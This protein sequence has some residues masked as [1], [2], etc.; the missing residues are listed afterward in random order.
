MRVGNITKYL[1]KGLSAKGI[2]VALLLFI[3]ATSVLAGNNLLVGKLL[4][5]GT[6][7]RPVTYKMWV[8]TRSGDSASGSAIYQNSYTAYYA[9]VLN[10][11]PNWSNNEVV[12]AITEKDDGRYSVTDLTL[13]GSASTQNFPDATFQPI[14][15]PTANPGSGAITVSWPAAVDSGTGNI[16]GYNVYRSADGTNFSQINGSIVAASP[17]PSYSDASGT[18]GITYYYKIKIVFRGEPNKVVSTNFSAASSGVQFPNAPVSVT[19]SSL[20]HGTVGVAYNRTLEAT[21]GNGTYAW[22]ISS[23]SLPTGLGLNASTGVISGT[24][25]AAGTSNFTV[26]VTSNG[27]A[28]KSLLIVVDPA[29]VTLVS[30]A[31]TPA[32]PNVMVDQTKQFTATG[33]YSDLST[34]NITG[35]V[36]WQSLNIGVATM[37]GNTA[38]GVAPGTATIKA[39]S[40]AISG[41]TTLTV[42]P[43][44]PHP[45]ITRSPI[46]FNLSVTQG[47][48]VASQ[49]FTVGNSGDATLNYTITD[50]QNWLSET[51]DSGII[52][53]GGAS[54]TITINFDTTSLAQGPH[55]ATITVSDPGASNDPQ[56]I[57]VAL[58]VNPAPQ[59]VLSVD[60]AS[61]A[62]S[63]TQGQ[64]AA[65][66]N[67]TISN[68][69]NAGLNY[70]ITKDQS[71]LDVNKT[72]RTVAPSGS[73]SVNIVFNTTALSVGL[74]I[75]HITITDPSANGS[76]KTVT[77]NLN[78]TSAPLPVAEVIPSKLTVSAG[79]TI[80]ITLK[81]SESNQ[82]TTS[83]TA[84]NRAGLCDLTPYFSGIQIHGTTSINVVP[85]DLDHIV[86]LPH[87]V[88]LEQGRSATFTA[89]GYDVYGNERT[90]DIFNYAS[91]LGDNSTVTANVA[92]GDYVISAYKDG[93]SD[94][95]DIKVTSKYNSLIVKVENGKVK[96]SA[97]DALGSEVALPANASVAYDITGK[98]DGNAVAADGTIVEGS[99]EGDF[100]VTAT[101]TIGSQTLT[102]NC[103]V[104]INKN[105]PTIQAK[106]DN[107]DLANNIA[108]SSKP[109]IEINLT[110]GNGV[111]AVRIFI[112]GSEMTGFSL[113]A[114]N[115][116]SSSVSFTPDT[117][118]GSGSHALLIEAE[119]NLG[120]KSSVSAQGLKVYADLQVQG[121]PMN[122][123]NP[124]KPSVGNTTIN[125]RLTKDAE[126]KLMIY[127]FTGRLVYTQVFAAGSNGGRVGENDPTWNGK[128]FT[129]ASAGNGVCVYFITAGGKSIG[130]GEISIYE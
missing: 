56:T 127:D 96:L 45:I 33:T 2:L 4:P 101:V 10:F 128:S 103:I 24:P 53:Q 69:G 95:A 74:K 46:S 61:F 7:Y 25:T 119:D 100:T 28:T 57:S 83:W 48:N 26:E 102:G 27:T 116:A 11:S 88:T 72:S 125:Y 43:P 113:R 81:Y 126:V 68:T 30:I 15:N 31:V 108:I 104:N 39:T 90:G 41:Q 37:S 121:K 115:T 77:V 92:A 97:K 78:V 70:T 64:N 38:T 42:I 105:G 36:I 20:P 55:N 85:A 66:Q 79:E 82:V 123:P 17:S 14:P 106:I 130:S 110:D 93:K 54:Q 118:L 71:W 124:F 109:N 13:N 40:G 98:A 19:T 58:T 35:S 75:A 1:N 117:S 9:N 120:T 94:V 8:A 80:N 44:A 6:D 107:Q 65:N 89:K 129:G 3:T 16:A 73:D 87:S 50:N 76:P 5:A 52:A 18:S 23:G 99:Q 91:D 47:Q 86:I 84:P 32:N 63:V 122:Y 21:G 22:A 59:A 112:D 29:P 60:P 34:Q 49:T 12:V 62:L 114:Q 67:F 51:P 111:K